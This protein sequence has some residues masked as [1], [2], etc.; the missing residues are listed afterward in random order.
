[1]Q[2]SQAVKAVA[3][4]LGKQTKRNEFGAVYGEL[5]RRFEITSYKRLPAARFDEAMGFLTEW[6]I[7]L[8]GDSPF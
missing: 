2:I 8:T 6:H 3:I 5:Y 1:M 4:V 7:S